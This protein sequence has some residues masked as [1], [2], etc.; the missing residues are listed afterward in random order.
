MG[1]KYHHLYVSW[2]VFLLLSK[3][4]FARSSSFLPLPLKPHKAYERRLSMNNGF[5]LY[6]TYSLCQPFLL[7]IFCLEKTSVWTEFLFE[8]A[9]TACRDFTNI[10]FVKQRE[11]SINL[12]DTLVCRFNS[13]CLTL[14][15]Q[16]NPLFSS[17]EHAYYTVTALSHITVARN[18]LPNKNF[19]FQNWDD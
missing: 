11:K 3:S 5:T 13:Y 6:K 12:N 8:K 4:L 7:H 15:G 2:I 14:F 19:L 1:N 18:I 10:W 9:D 16:Q 17:V